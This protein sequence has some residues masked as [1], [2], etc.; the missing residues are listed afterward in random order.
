MSK[1]KSID[2][3]K[4]PESEVFNEKEVNQHKHLADMG[5]PIDEDEKMND[6]LKGKPG[7][8]TTKEEGFNEEKSPGNAGAFEGFED[9]EKR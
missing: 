2:P 9:Q 4:L 6:Q 7:N 3:A 8:R 5:K 1:D